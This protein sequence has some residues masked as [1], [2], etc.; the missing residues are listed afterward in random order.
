MAQNP[1]DPF[2]VQAADYSAFRPQYP[3]ELFSSLSAHYFADRSS[4]RASSAPSVVDVGCGSGQATVA[5]AQQF[6]S[7]VGVD[8]SEAQLKEAKQAPGVSYR[9]GSSKDLGG[10]TEADVVTAFQVRERESVI[11]RL[12]IGDGEREGIVFLLL[13]P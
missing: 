12:G 2:A 5:L 3:K 8:V 9:A 1:T 13:S 6:G 7:A 11:G 10:A 4:L